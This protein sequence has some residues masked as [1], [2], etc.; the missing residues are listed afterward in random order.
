M[1][2][3]KNYSIRNQTFQYLE[4]LAI[5]MVIDDHS[6][7]SL[8]IF[9]NIFPY[10]SFFMP[11]FVFISGY[12]YKRKGVV[13]NLRHKA[14]HLLL[15]YIEWSLVG[16]LVAY[17]LR[18]FGVVDWYV[19]PFNLKALYNI[20]FTG[21]L[22]SITGA[23]WFALM[24]FWISVGYNL[25]INVLLRYIINH[26]RTIFTFLSLMF[27]IFGLLICEACIQ[28]L[29]TNSALTFVFRTIWYMQF[30]HF[31][32]I[33]H[34]Y[35]EKYIQNKSDL[36]ICASCIIINSLLI[37]M[38]GKDIISFP[39]SSQMN[40]FKIFWTPL[41]TSM[42]GIWFWYMICRMV[43]GS[44]GERKI[45]NLLAENSFTIMC[46]HLLFVNVPNFFLC[47][48]YLMGNKKFNK[49]DYNNF[50]G[51]AWYRYNDSSALVGFFFGIVG[52]LLLAIFINF[53]K[54]VLFNIDRNANN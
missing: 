22:S 48:Q 20:F 13:D 33:F 21:Q 18:A 47:D 19:S 51:G 32:Y 53:V 4:A 15:P 3:D 36:I 16:D 46:S 42:T 39:H 17:I 27:V 29:N 43:S 45:I 38:Y 54:R 40:S 8:G 25:I 44:F 37:V 34:M 9:T 10:D 12:F 14:K 49:F 35:L 52:S 11:L 41:I 1:K 50:R 31:G 2:K 24:L 6:R 26:K 28:K 30:Y 5:I 7:S 23:A